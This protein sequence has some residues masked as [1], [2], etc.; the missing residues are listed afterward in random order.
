MHAAE[1]RIVASRIVGALRDVPGASRAARHAADLATRAT[2]SA[3]REL[4][5]RVAR[6]EVTWSSLQCADTWLSV[7]HPR[8]YRALDAER[9]RGDQQMDALFAELFRNGD[10]FVVANHDPPCDDPD[11]A[12]RYERMLT[13]LLERLVQVLADEPPPQ[14]LVRCAQF[15]TD[16]RVGPPAG[17]AAT[18]DVR[19]CRCSLLTTRPQTYRAH[20]HPGIVLADFAANRLH[21]EAVPRDSWAAFRAASRTLQVVRR[22]ARLDRELPTAAGEGAPRDAVTAA[23]AGAP[24]ALDGAGWAVEQANLW[25]RALERA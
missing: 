15:H 13:G 5:D 24:A 3:G 21:R 2:G 7:M 23:F 22:P 8:A 19:G 11:A 16:A 17:R 20:V 14:V 12:T 18:F 25:V 6:D 1:L 9:L 4:V 10:A